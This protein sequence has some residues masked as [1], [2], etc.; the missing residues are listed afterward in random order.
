MDKSILD[1]TIRCDSCGYKIYYED[2][3][4]NYGEDLEPQTEEGDMLIYC[5]TCFASWHH[6]LF[7]RAFLDEDTQN[8][9]DWN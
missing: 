3:T 5:D 8:S 6:A 7:E 9:E 2:F 4:R 1:T